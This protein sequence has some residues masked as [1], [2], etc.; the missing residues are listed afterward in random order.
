[1]WAWVAKVGRISLREPVRRLTTPAG[2]V[3]AFEG[4]QVDHR[5]GSIKP[6]EFR[7]SLD[8]AGGE[9][10]HPLFDPDPID[11]A[12]RIHVGSEGSGLGGDHDRRVIPLTLI[13]Q[14][15]FLG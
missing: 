14:C 2:R 5:D 9:F 10:Q 7:L 11:G 3:F 8:A 15:Q 12:A 13:E 4:S 6:P 1:M